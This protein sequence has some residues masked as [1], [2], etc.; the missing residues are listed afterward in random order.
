[1]SPLAG[2]RQQSV[3]TRVSKMYIENPADM[4]PHSFSF[5]IFFCFFLVFVRPLIQFSLFF[6]VFFLFSLFFLFFVDFLGGG[7]NCGPPAPR[8]PLSQPPSSLS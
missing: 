5:P 6:I 1:M 3:L 2:P 8:Q 4:P 7:K